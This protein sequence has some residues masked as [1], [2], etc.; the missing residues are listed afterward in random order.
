MNLRF[1]MQ[2]FDIKGSIMQS[3]G[4]R[5]YSKC[6]NQMKNLT[7]K[8]SKPKNCEMLAYE[9]RWLKNICFTAEFVTQ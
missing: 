9:E 8:I 3:E 2:K 5:V 7:M 6:K 1:L 4:L